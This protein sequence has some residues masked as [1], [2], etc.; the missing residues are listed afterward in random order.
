MTISR[1]SALLSLSVSPLAASLA[2]SAQAQESAKV[3]TVASGT[4]EDGLPTQFWGDKQRLE[5]PGSSV[6]RVMFENQGVQI[7]GN[8]FSPERAS[9]HPAKHPAV[10]V[11]G[12]VAFVKEQSPLQYAARLVS[13]GY[14]VL[15]FDPRFHGE[16][17]GE[18]RRFESGAEKTS[19]LSAAVDFLVGRAD[20]DAE[21]VSLLGICQGVNWVVEAA[22]SDP[23]VKSIALVA[24]HYL[25]PEVAEMYLGS[26]ANVEARIARSREA[27]IRYRDT[28][29]ADYIHIVS[30]SLD[31][32]D[33]NA[34]LRAPHIQMFYIR[35]ADRNPDL[36]HRGLWENRIAA[37]SEH[38][39]WGHRI[40]LALQQV[41]TPLLMIH[42][43]NAASG[44][45]L[46]QR[47]F[48]TVPTERKKLVWMGE[49][50]QLQFYEDPITISA[51]VSHLAQF[52]SATV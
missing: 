20:V 50:S 3:S 41:Q 6:E 10:I 47:L 45:E 49:Q 30:P 7:V 23:R 52:L 29:N 9:S 37:M 28:G 8:L 35:W 2:L 22:L 5:W 32:P 11:L 1:R 34:L 13:E 33:A 25:M 24:G 44:A 16:S 4:S 26:P 46:P 21:R 51:T 18:P 48:D 19:D 14:V 36:A 39:I 31:K 38:L 27:E 43:Q 17:G 42:S 12:P 15:V 40:D